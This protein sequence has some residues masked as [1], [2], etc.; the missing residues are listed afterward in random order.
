PLRGDGASA[1]SEAVKRLATKPRSTVQRSREAP[2]GEAAKHRAANREPPT[3]LIRL[4]HTDFEVLS[5]DVA[6]AEGEA[7]G[8]G[9]VFVEIR[10]LE[11]LALLRRIDR[12]HIVLA[13]R[14]PTDSVL[15]GLIG[16]RGHDL[17]RLRLP[18]RRVGGEGEDG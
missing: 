11:P 6:V 7:G 1:C 9:A 17:T 15:A 4:L 16:P 13:G 12:R 10:R 18:E 3:S 14:Q 2:C 5:L 8:A